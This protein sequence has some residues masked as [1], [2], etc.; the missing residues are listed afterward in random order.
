MQRKNI[1]KTNYK[2]LIYTL[3]YIVNILFYSQQLAASAFFLLQEKSTF[4]F[5]TIFY[6]LPLLQVH[7]SGSTFTFT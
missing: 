1:T 2:C 4:V 6:F 3:K 5:S 7:I